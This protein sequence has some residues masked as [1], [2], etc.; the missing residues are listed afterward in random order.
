[1]IIP[2]ALGSLAALILVA[3]MG[4]RNMLVYILI[5]IFVSGALA[6]AGVAA[7]TYALF[8]GL[9]IAAMALWILTHVEERVVERAVVTLLSVALVWASNNAV[10]AQALGALSYDII[11]PFFAALAN[12]GDVVL[13]VAGFGALFAYMVLSSR[14]LS[15]AEENPIIAI[16]YVYLANA[17]L[18]ALI[19]PMPDFLK[20]ALGLALLYPLG[21]AIRGNLEALAE[22]APVLYLLPIQ[23]SVLVQL[24]AVMALVELAMAILSRKHL[25]GASMWAAALLFVA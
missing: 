2:L 5:E 1:M 4:S 12:V 7:A 9:F 18:S 16:G 10:A 19:A 8:S 14:I 3:L 6:L 25:V 13:G 24:G 17:V 21:S 15:L 22:V 23:P 11:E 20:L